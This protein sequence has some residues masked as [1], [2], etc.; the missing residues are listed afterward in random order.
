MFASLVR[1]LV[2]VGISAG[3]SYIRARDLPWIPDVAALRA[4]QEL[5]EKLRATAGVTLEELLSLI[6]QGA[7]VIDA[8]SQAEFEEGHL[9]IEGD[10]PVLNVPAD[11]VDAHVERLVQLQGVPVVLYCESNTCDYAEELYAALQEFGFVDI[12][13]YFPGWEGIV[14]AGL[15]TATGPDSWTGFYDEWMDPLLDE[16]DAYGDQELFDAN[17]PE[18][19][20]P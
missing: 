19:I 1:I 3:A 18:E 10:P 4:A 2:I 8:R 9:A 15:K 7:V 6:D 16:D 14:E 13:I 12:W 20:E 5:H 11:E 17:T